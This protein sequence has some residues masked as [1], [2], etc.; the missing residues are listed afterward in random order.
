MSA[1]PSVVCLL[2]CLVRLAAHLAPSTARTRLHHL[3]T[4]SRLHPLGCRWATVV[5]KLVVA[6]VPLHSPGARVVSAIQSPSSPVCLSCLP[7]CCALTLPPPPLPCGRLDDASSYHLCECGTDHHACPPS[8]PPL[9]AV[10]GRPACSAGWSYG[11]RGY[12]P[13]Y[14]SGGH[15]CGP[16]GSAAATGGP[17]HPVGHAAYPH[18]PPAGG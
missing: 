8:S 16:G 17:H 6:A 3:F 9:P 14:R 13:V 7:V 11:W 15:V 5:V 12:L 1:R 18:H 2:V 10:S 4:R